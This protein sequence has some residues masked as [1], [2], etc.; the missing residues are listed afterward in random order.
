MDV[1]PAARLH[2]SICSKGSLYLTLLRDGTETEIRAEVARMKH[3][4]AGYP[5]IYSTADAVLEGTPG[6]NLIA[7]VRACR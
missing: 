1:R 2:R 3:A 4:V 7:F 5:H 6:P